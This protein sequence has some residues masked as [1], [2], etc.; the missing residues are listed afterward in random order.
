MESKQQEP[1]I[2]ELIEGLVAVTLAAKHLTKQAL[3][4]KQGGEPATQ[5]PATQEEKKN[6]KNE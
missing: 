6:G 3:K 2:D 5:E 1:T 4:M